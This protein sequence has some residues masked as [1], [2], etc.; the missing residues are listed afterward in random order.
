VL[1]ISSFG[2]ELW[3]KALGIN[4][5]VAVG[6][7]RVD[8]LKVDSARANSSTGLSIFIINKLVFVSFRRNVLCLMFLNSWEKTGNLCFCRYYD[9]YTARIYAEL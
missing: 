8:R 5:T 1:N 9:A 4:G 6:W 3:I 2:L 7:G